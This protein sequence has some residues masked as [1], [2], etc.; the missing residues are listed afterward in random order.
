MR[1]RAP[2]AKTLASR[3]AAEP[4]LDVVDAR[5]DLLNHVLD[6]ERG[7]VELDG[8]RRAPER[9][10]RA[11]AVSLVALHDFRA[12]RRKLWLF[13]AHGELVE[14]ALGAHLDAGGEKHLHLGS[15]EH[16]GPDVAAL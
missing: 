4:S 15:R 14:A 1:G 10:H 9:R 16:D 3:L 8:I 7:A 13:T 6:A 11:R 5:D 2:R 12:H